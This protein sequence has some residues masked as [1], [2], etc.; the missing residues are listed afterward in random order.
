YT[1]GGIKTV[2]FPSRTVQF[3]R[4]LVPI[5]FKKRRDMNGT[6]SRRQMVRPTTQ[7][8]ASSN[9]TPEESKKAERSTTS[10]DLLD[11]DAI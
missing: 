10:V 11:V 9:Y 8:V 7:T 5:P 6:C 1:V 4:K 2:S 3:N